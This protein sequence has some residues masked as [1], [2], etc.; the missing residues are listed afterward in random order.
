MAQNVQKLWDELVVELREISLIGISEIAVAIWRLYTDETLLSSFFSR[1]FFSLSVATSAL[2]LK[3]SVSS[4]EERWFVIISLC[5]L[6]SRD[7]FA[8]TLFFFRRS[9]YCSVFSIL[10]VDALPRFVVPLFASWSISSH[11]SS[12]LLALFSVGFCS[13]VQF[14]RITLVTRICVRVCVCLWLTWL[15]SERTLPH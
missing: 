3:F 9:Q 2:S 4:I 11:S 6:A 5:R 7:F 13:A 8:D 10:L 1:S 12:T 14:S 15:P